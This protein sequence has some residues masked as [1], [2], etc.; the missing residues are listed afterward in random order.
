[1][2]RRLLDQ[3]N[4]ELHHLRQ[5]AAEFALQ[6]PVQAGRLAIDKEGKE[7]CPDPYVERL[8]EGFAF[9]TARVQLKL[10][11]EFPRLTQSLLETVYPQYLCSIPSMAIARFEPDYQGTQPDGYSIAR[12]TVLRSNARPGERTACEYRTAHNVELWPLKI[13]EAR[14]YTRDVSQLNLPPSLEA[15][16]AFRLRLQ[17][18]GGHPLK[19]IKLD[20]LPF[21]LRGADEV[22]VSIYEQIFSHGV[23]VAIHAVTTERNKNLF[24]LPATTI[25]RIGF[26]EEEALLPNSPRGFQGYRFLREY[27]AFP[28]RFLFFELSGLAEAFQ[29]SEGDQ[30]DVMI[31]FDEQEVRLEEQGIDASFFE[32]YC[33][34]I[35]NLFSKRADRILMSDRFSEFHV[36]ADKT[37]PLDFEIFQIESV[38]AFGSRADDVQEFRPFYL[39][40][41]TDSRTSAFFTVHRIPRELSEKEKKFGP[42]SS[43]TGSE[44]YLSLVDSNAAPY[45]TDLQQLGVTALC[46]NRHL[47]ML[48]SRSPGGNDLSMEIAGPVRSIACLTTPTAP[49][50]AFADGE[51]PWRVV[52]H[53]SLNYLSILDGPGNEGALALKQLLKLYVDSSDAIMRKQI[54]GIRSTQSRAIVRRVQ[55]PG[56]IA[57]ARGLE[58]SVLFDEIAFEGLGI[59]I[60]GGVL[61]QF[62]ARYVSLNSFTETVIK[63]VQ[64]GDI[65]RWKAQ[66]GQRH[67]I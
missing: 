4:R 50:P 37:R 53:L 17:S 3:Y 22:P 36:V 35:I 11:A 14:Y 61:E 30:V 13:I 67:L 31:I 63:S 41:D 40:K 57:F 21:F 29:S 48:I 5:M 49:R 43:Y 27:F 58:I 9:L 15:R 19:E 54:E 66:V 18:T 7:I 2:D 28:Q 46:T 23:A 12:G 56:P 45:R 26:R 60:L 1:M 8:L 42:K 64:R 62:F 52:S 47:P 25:R 16:A 51:L 59:F 33:T 34:P 6:N 55:T 32:L 38:S 65:I 44:V 10:D 20:R 24:V 39:T